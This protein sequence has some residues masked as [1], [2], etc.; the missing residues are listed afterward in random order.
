M[1]DNKASISLNEKDIALIA[2]KAANKKKASDIIVQCVGELIGVTE[3]FV[4]ASA[5]NN[6]QVKAI[7]EQIEEDIRDEVGIKPLHREET[8]DNSWEL[9]D[10]GSVVVHVFQPETRVFYRLESL[11]SVAPLLDLEKEANILDID[12]S[13]RILSLMHSKTEA[14]EE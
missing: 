9:L 8:H 4:I 6:R 3:Y 2:A 11:W 5:V 12:Y 13:D 14:N 7:I 10:Y 1:S